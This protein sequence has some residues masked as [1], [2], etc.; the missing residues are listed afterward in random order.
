M[1]KRL[2][3]SVAAI[4][5]ASAIPALA[6]T[7]GGEPDG[8]RHPYV[9][10]MVAQDAKG[11]PLWRCSGTLLSPRLF[12]TAG[13]CTEPPAAHVEIWFDADVEGGRPANGYPFAGDAGG[14]VV[15]L[16]TPAEVARVR[17]S[18]TGRYL[19]EV[20]KTAVGRN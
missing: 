14:R 4:I 10:L 6:I 20:M 13:H 1:L 2:V 11:T 8:D 12:L 5:S 9:G 16:G 19:R 15:A 7:D 3:L 18:H 17:E